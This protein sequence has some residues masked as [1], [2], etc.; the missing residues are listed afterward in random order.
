MMTKNEFAIALIKIFPE[1]KII[2]EEHYD[3]YEEL[4]AHIFFSDAIDSYLFPLLQLNEDIDIIE[5]Y[6]DFIEEMWK[7][8]NDEIINV[9]DVT[10]LEKLSN[11][12]VVWTNFGEYISED[13]KKYINDEVLV[14]NIL[15]LNIQRL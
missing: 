3:D 9:V 10:I 6:C 7:S 11:D 13:F 15:M 12:V 4:L 1:K 2:L 8:N 14:Q 5:K